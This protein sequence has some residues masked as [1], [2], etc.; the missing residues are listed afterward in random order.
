LPSFPTRI[1]ERRERER[2][3]ERIYIT[4]ITPCL[5]TLL[6]CTVVVVVSQINV[7]I[8]I[9]PS[10]DESI[11]SDETIITA[12]E[13]EVVE[14]VEEKNEEVVEKIEEKNEEVVAN[15]QEEDI[16]TNVDSTNE[17]II[18]SNKDKKTPALKSKKKTVQKR[19]TS[20]LSEILYT[21]KQ[22]ISYRKMLH[23]KVLLYYV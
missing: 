19:A 18:T 11:M 20:S 8:R 9:I 14:K 15:V 5:Y 6:S 3:R 1:L 17:D 12:K 13:I 10:F 7:D 2:E 21:I 23:V 22:N 16:N 4:C